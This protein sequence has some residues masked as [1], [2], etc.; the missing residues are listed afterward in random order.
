MDHYV[1]C[2]GNYFM[3]VRNNAMYGFAHC[4]IK[5]LMSLTCLRSNGV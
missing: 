5:N 3:D 2:Y 4:N 1:S